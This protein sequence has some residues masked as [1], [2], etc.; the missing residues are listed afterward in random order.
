MPIVNRLH[1]VLT[2]ALQ[3]QDMKDRL[4]AEGAE[5]IGNTPQEF[6]A[7]IKSEI[8]RWAVVVKAS[9]MKAE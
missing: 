9:G 6:Q 7:F 2:R 4:T 5:P 3:S 1:G 8:E